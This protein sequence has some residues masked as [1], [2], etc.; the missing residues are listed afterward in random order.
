MGEKG[1]RSGKTDP[2]DPLTSIP[3]VEGAMVFDERGKLLHLYPKT[4]SL[5]RWP[6]SLSK[7]FQGEES[8]L[9]AEARELV[10][11]YPRAV[12]F[13]RKMEEG[14]KLA[15]GF[16]IQGARKLEI[17]E[18]KISRIVIVVAGPNCSASLVRLNL[19]VM[20]HSWRSQGI[21]RVFP[22]LPSKASGGGLMGKI[23]RRRKAE[24]GS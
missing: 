8:G 22:S 11:F 19:D 10:A 16:G 23:F 12:V 3:G 15:D 2:L 13:W 5:S 6:D 7:W 1:V 24:E 4:A 20:E 17:D 18:G 14:R 21:D 9:L